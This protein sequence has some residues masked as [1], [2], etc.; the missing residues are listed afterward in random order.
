MLESLKLKKFDYCVAINSTAYFLMA[1]YFVV[2]TFNLFSIGIC[3]FLGFDVELFYNGFIHS[4]KQWTV[5]NMI[6]VF[7]VG[8]A[9]TILTAVGFELLYRKQRKYVRGIKMLFLWIYLI[10]IVWFFG[11]VI[12]G[13]FFNFGIGT[14][15]RAYHV[16]FFLR[17]VL[18]LVS[19]FLLAFFGIRSRKHVRVSANLYYQKLSGKV[20]QSFF[21]TQ[22]ALPI[23]IGLI[24]VI[25]LKIPD[26]GMYNY[27][28]IY[29]LLCFIFFLAGLFYKSKKH[30]SIAFKAHDV[31]VTSKNR[32]NCNLSWIAIICAIAVL[33]IIRIGLA[34]GIT[35]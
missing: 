11:N 14:A 25:L 26:V 15:L 31:D 7:F 12:V 6:L 29:V 1:Y 3:A 35:F 13:A 4:G 23:V 2:F 10:S 30:E 32:K 8:N 16:P 22:I 18:A 5:G 21:I 19:I 34:S 9:Y 28:D 33:A 27:Y 17:L 24:I 20:T